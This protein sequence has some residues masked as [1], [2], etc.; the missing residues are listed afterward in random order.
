MFAFILSVIFGVL[1]MVV[2]VSIIVEIVEKGLCSSTTIMIIVTMGIFLVAALMH[3]QEFAN[4]FAIFIYY[5]LIPA[6]YLILTIYSLCNLHVISWGTREVTPTNTTKQ[7]EEERLREEVAKKVK[8]T[9]PAPDPNLNDGVPMTCGSWCRC[10][11]CPRPGDG[12]QDRKLNDVQQ[13]VAV[14]RKQLD[15][16]TTYLSTGVKPPSGFETLVNNAQTEA[17]TAMPN[18]EPVDAESLTADVDS[19][20]FYIIGLLR[21]SI[22]LHLDL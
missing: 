12:P 5:L 4:L 10:L 20:W 16:L 17:L 2:F 6:M 14:V 13:N 11:C 15:Q 22:D 19:G 1:Q 8:T 18:H 3:P 21:V 7:K 9:A